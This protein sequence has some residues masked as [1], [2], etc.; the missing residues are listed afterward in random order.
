MNKVRRFSIRSKLLLIFGILILITNVL[1][2]VLAVTVGK[3][4]VLENVEQHLNTKAKD[5]AEIIDRRLDALLQFLEGVARMPA[6][7]DAAY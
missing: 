4:A 1:L 3:R 5:T 7:Y 6:L 2:T